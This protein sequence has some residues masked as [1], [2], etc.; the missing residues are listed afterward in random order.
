MSNIDQ[1]HAAS[2]LQYSLANGT[3]T[4]VATA[5][6]VHV[7]L[8]TA[9]G[10]A[11]V[12]GTELP[13]GGGYTSGTGITPVTFAAVSAG[14]TSNSG[15]LTVTNMPAATIVGVELWDSSGTPHRLW[16]GALNSSKAM[17]S[18]DSFTISAAALA[19]SLG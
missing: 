18:G 1:A 11:T 6:N 4:P 15:A 17:N 8:M 19:I 7:R 14:A 5:G 2:L 12:N 3:G 13:T 10:S 16:F 9:N